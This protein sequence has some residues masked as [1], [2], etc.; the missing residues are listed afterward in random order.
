MSLGVLNIESLGLYFIRELPGNIEGEG[1]GLGL[2]WTE[3]QVVG[4]LET[5]FLY[6]TDRLPSWLSRPAI[7]PAFNG[8]GCCKTALEFLDGDNKRI[9]ACYQE[10]NRGRSGCVP[11]RETNFSSRLSQIMISL[12][13]S[14]AVGGRMKQCPTHLS[15]LS[16][17]SSL[18][19]RSLPS[20]EK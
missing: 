17:G 10:L 16:P 9:R 12:R 14:G 7:S 3:C 8:S 2:P 5:D 15:K 13:S 20:Q 4:K 18:P 6:L 1:M 19:A 11:Q